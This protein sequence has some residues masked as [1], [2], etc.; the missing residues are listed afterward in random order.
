MNPGVTV[1]NAT[2]LFADPAIQQKLWDRILCD[3]MPNV[4]YDVTVDLSHH[5][6]DADGKPGTLHSHVTFT[7]PGATKLLV[8][9]MNQIYETDDVSEWEYDTK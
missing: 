5:G 1:S 4:C 3:V 6:L 8:V 2:G 7:R 9:M